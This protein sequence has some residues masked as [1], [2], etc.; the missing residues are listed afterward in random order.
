MSV[1][2]LELGKLPGD[3]EST[4][5]AQLLATHRDA[6]ERVLVA[7]RAVG[8]PGEMFEASAEWAMTPETLAQDLAAILTLRAERGAEERRT[9]AD[10]FPE[11]ADPGRLGTRRAPIVD[12]V[13]PTKSRLLL[14][15]CQNRSFVG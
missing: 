14:F 6:L 4:F 1:L 5:P 12:L 3:F 9:I 13:A 11:L 7:A 8:L 2:Q 10:A 15:L